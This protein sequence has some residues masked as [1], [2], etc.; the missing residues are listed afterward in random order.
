MAGSEVMVA[1]AVAVAAVAALALAVAA[2]AVSAG[3]LVAVV[4]VVEQEDLE[5]VQEPTVELVQGVAE[6]AK[7]TTL[8]AVQALM[9][10]T[11]ARVL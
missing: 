4:A 10:A 2:V 6:Q 5:V 3:S 7:A 9:V 1:R 11:V 8:L